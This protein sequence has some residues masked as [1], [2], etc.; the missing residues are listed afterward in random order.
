MPMMTS[1]HITT[2]M[3]H[4]PTS[5]V[6]QVTVGKHEHTECISISYLGD[7]L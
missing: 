3:A 6:I 7:L 1:I 4:F 5:L 2:N